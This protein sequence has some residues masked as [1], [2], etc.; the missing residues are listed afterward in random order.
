MKLKSIL[1]YIVLVFSFCACKKDLGNYTYTPPSE[2]VV[3]YFMD[4]T[5]NALIGDTLTLK[6]SVTIADADPL[7]DL[8]YE[9][10][11][12]VDEEAR[13]AIYTGYPLKMLYNLSPKLR[14]ARLTITDNRNGM[15]YFYPFKILGST[16][17]SVGRTVL[18]VD[19]GVTKLSFIKADNRTVLS[20]LYFNLNGE[21]LPVNPVQLFAKPLAYQAGT[22]EDYWVICQDNATGG[23]VLDGGSMLRKRYFTGQFLAAP[24]TLVPAAF[25]A[26]AGTPT[27]VINGKLYLSIFQTAPFAP[28]FG[29]FSNP[30]TGDYFLSKYYS[31]S[32]SRSYYFGFDTKAGAFVCF[33]GGG[34]YYGPDYNVDNS[35][36]TGDLFDP[37]NVGMTNLVFMKPV[38]GTSYAFF[39]N[40]S[41]ETYEFS[42]LLAM[43]DFNSRKISPLRKRL[44]KGSALVMADT[45]WERSLSDLY[46]FTSNDKVYRYNPVNEEL[47]ALDANFSGKKVSMIKLSDD[48]NMLMAG[49]DGAVL[50]LDVSVGASGAIVQTITGIPGSPVDIIVKKL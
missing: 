43:D 21:A 25:E 36:A 24:S 13:E 50:G 31:F 20:D 14:T 46:Y 42:F 35:R 12:S 47:R 32:P 9:W 41:G 10:K 48:G 16:P 40:A 38:S 28:D 49:V 29:K 5:F 11:I 27:G 18:S 17:F 8:S 19:N 37:K 34:T 33:N 4:A 7:K 6:P 2:P 3:P 45:K 1:L 30:Q 44:F 26:S 39:R 23:V 22:I 15:K